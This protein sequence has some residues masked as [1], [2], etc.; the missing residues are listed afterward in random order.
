MLVLSF[1]LSYDLFSDLCSFNL[2]KTLSE[3]L[4]A[5]GVVYPSVLI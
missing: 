2:V 5:L 3:D 4:L 1:I